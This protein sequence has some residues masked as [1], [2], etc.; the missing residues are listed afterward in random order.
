MR[1][2]RMLLRS[3]HFAARRTSLAVLS[4]MTTLA[5]T[6]GCG[7]SEEGPSQPATRPA[8]QQQPQATSPRADRAP[9]ADATPSSADVEALRRQIENE[10]IANAYDHIAPRCASRGGSLSYC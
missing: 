10:L 9:T 6:A 7:P 5:L 3:A 1:M 8:R 2:R 4:I